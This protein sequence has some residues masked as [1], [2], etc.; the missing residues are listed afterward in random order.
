ME[1]AKLSR[2]RYSLRKFS[3]APLEREKLDLILEAGHNA[4][5][6]KNYQPQRIFVANTPEALAKADKCTE[7]HFHP[8]VIL[9]IG[10]DASISAK[11]T[12]GHFDFGMMD[13]TIAITQ[14]MLQATDL[15]VGNICIGLFDPEKI[16]EEFPETRGTTM[17]SMLFLGYPAEGAKPAYLHDDRIPIGDMVKYL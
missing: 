12:I 1:F 6:A 10:Y 8:P 13:A 16:A 15:G 4:P 7:C 5:T 14:M 11:H 17:I 9:M 2:E 3:D